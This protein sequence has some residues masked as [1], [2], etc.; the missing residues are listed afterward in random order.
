MSLKVIKR[1]VLSDEIQPLFNTAVPF[2]LV[3]SLPCYLYRSVCL[4]LADLQQKLGRLSFMRRAVALGP[5]LAR[6]V[7]V[8]IMEAHAAVLLREEPPTLTIWT[9]E[10]ECNGQTY[11]DSYPFIA[12]SD[13][14]CIFL[15]PAAVFF[16]YKD[17]RYWLNRCDE[18]REP[19][20]CGRGY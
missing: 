14:I 18:R 13:C 8:F 20:G 10:D 3:L 16:W 4:C 2:L 19:R 17:V 7:V 15:S 6:L 9:N 11:P 12:R 1:L 5:A